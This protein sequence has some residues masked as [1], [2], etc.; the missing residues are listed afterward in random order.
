L[1]KAPGSS[2]NL[3]ARV[4]AHKTQD[5]HRGHCTKRLLLLGQRRPTQ[6]RSSASQWF[7]LRAGVLRRAVRASGRPMRFVA[8]RRQAPGRQLQ[9]HF[10]RRSFINLNE[11]FLRRCPWQLAT[12][13]RFGYKAGV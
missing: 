8:R 5:R 3:Q 11:A 1:R 12:P 2:N 4:S 9:C 13:P 10:G 6:R 7:A